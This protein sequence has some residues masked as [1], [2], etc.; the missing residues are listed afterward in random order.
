LELFNHGEYFEAHEALEEAWNEDDTLA[1]ELYPRY[2]AGGGSLF[3]NRARQLQR[4]DQNVL[5][6]RQW[7]DRSRKP[8][9]AWM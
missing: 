2:L 8:A 1:G 7:I 4:V 5:R 9:A 3:T 6:L